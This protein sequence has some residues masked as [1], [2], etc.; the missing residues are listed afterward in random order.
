[1]FKHSEHNIQHFIKGSLVSYKHSYA[2][3]E[4]SRLTVK[5]DR[6]TDMHTDRQTNTGVD[7]SKFF[8]ETKILGKSKTMVITE[9]T[10]AW[11]F[12]NYCLPPADVCLQA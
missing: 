6:K 8:W 5:A 9:L 3:T 10:N 11:A 4:A 12:L 7:L 1:M 2:R